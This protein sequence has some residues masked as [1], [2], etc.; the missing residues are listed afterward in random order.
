MSWNIRVLESP[1]VSALSKEAQ[2]MIK[3]GA[4]KDR[5]APPLYQIVFESDDGSFSVRATESDHEKAIERL[6]K[7]M[8][9]AGEVDLNGSSG[10][11]R[12]GGPYMA[13]FT[14]RYQITLK[15]DGSNNKWKTETV[16]IGPI[17]SK[18]LPDMRDYVIRHVDEKYP[19]YER[20]EQGEWIA[21]LRK[22][23]PQ[24]TK[25]WPV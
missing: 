3:S 11:K 13:R 9:E 10:K 23:V 24:G 8:E 19:S 25:I 21:K 17:S 20:N 12:H 4:L 6:A 2:A 7:F 14:V 18:N 1:P 15:K 5:P 16:T 22:T